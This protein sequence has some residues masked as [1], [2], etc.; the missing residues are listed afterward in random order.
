MFNFNFTLRN[1]V[2]RDHRFEDIW[3]GYKKLS[4]NWGTELQFY[5]DW[6]T[7]FEISVSVRGNADFHRGIN[8]VFGC[9][10]FVNFDLYDGRHNYDEEDDADDKV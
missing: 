7:W 5:R 10:V 2:N 9:L 3:S 8:I 4:K 6:N 1:P